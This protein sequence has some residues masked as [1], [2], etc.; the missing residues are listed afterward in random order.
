MR[1]LDFKEDKYDIIIL[2]PPALIKSKK[3][4]HQGYAAYLKLNREVMKMIK[5]PG[6]LI[7]CSCSYHL[8]EKDFIEMLMKAGQKESCLHLA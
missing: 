5:I 2:D 6:W 4:F 8:S 1:H 7:S 3:Y